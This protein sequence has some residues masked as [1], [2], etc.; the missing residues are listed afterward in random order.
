MTN[1]P[2]LQ[3]ITTLLSNAQAIAFETKI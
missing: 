2:S 1:C 3:V